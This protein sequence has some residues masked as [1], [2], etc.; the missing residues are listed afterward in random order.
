MSVPNRLGRML[1]I[2]AVA[3]ALGGCLARAETLPAF[4]VV[5]DIQFGDKEGSV[6]RDYRGSLKRLET[7][8]DT[9]NR[10]R[11]D[12]VI[13]LGDIVDGI[14]TNAVASA[15]DLDQVLQVFNRLTAPTYHVIGNHCLNIGT[16]ALALKLGLTNFYYTFTVPTAKGWRFV[17]LDGNDAGYGV[18]SDRQLAWFRDALG[19]AQ[20]AGEKVICFCHFPLLKTAAEHHRMAKPE[21]ILQTLDAHTCVAA[22]IAGHEHAGGYARQRHVHHLTMRGLVEAPGSTAFARFALAGDR[23]LETG[24]G[25]EPSRELFLG[26]AS[27]PPTRRLS[28]ENGRV[29]PDDKGVHINAHGGGVLFREGVYY[30]YGEHK[31]EGKA[32]NMAHVGVHVYS[33][34]DL[35]NWKDEGI[36]LKVSDDPASEIAKEC[37]LER[38]KVIY[39][40]KTGKYVMW[41]HLELKGQG[42]SAARSGVAVADAPT[43]PFIYLRSLRPDAG[44]W[45]VNVNEGQKAA[46]GTVGQMKGLT[47]SGGPNPDTPKHAILAR[48]FAGGQMA[49]DMNLF[50]DDDGQAY[51]IFASEENST[52]HIS[53]L[54]DDYLSHAGTYVRLFEHRWHEAPALCKRGGRY[55]LL[56]SGCTGWAPNAARSAVAPSLWGPW[57]ELANPC[58]GVNPLNRL[59]AEKTFGGQSTFILPVQGK[60]D[61]FIALFDIWKPDDAIDG[62]YVWLPLRFTDEGFTV[63]WRDTWDLSVFD[64]AE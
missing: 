62:R 16:N 6:S 21:E 39:N 10:Q 29:W 50:V 18:V 46:L 14:P 7:C 1:S 40:A 33:S 24:N 11:L 60:K 30:W 54:S 19:Q 52:L 8:V 12:F 45:P 3:S 32:G 56:S 41:F 48:D 26:G 49:R 38:P 4:G 27:A 9:F 20:A 59:G 63:T 5:A 37:V 57:T 58:V 28:F 22:W 42:Y 44:V 47:F 64:R 43:G 51:H 25:N 23:I 17:V 55:Y 13:Q 2:M 31:I 36:A 61:A 53:L 15:K 34:K 35:T